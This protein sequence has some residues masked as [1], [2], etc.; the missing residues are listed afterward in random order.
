MLGGGPNAQR[1]HSARRRS[2]SSNMRSRH[3]R[4]RPHADRAGQQGLA[5]RVPSRRPRRHDHQ[6]RCSTKVPG[7]RSADGRGRDLGLRR[8]PPARRATTSP[9]SPRILAGHRRRA[10]RHREP[11][12]LVV[13]AD[14]PHGRARDQGRRGRRLHRRRRRDG[15]PVP[16]R[17]PTATPARTTRSSPTPRR[18]PRRARRRPADSWTPPAGLPD[19]YIAMG[20]TAENVAEIEGVTPR[21][22][23][24]VRR[25]VAAARRRVAGER[26]LR[27]GDHAGHHRPTA[28]SCRKDDGPRAGTTVEKLATL[29][30]VF[31]PDGKVTAGNACPLNDGAAAVVVMS[32]TKAERA[33][34]HAARPHRRQRRE[35]RS[36]RR[37]WASA[38]SRRAARR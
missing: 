14:D 13:A 27:A 12:L 17:Q 28:R 25:A 10:R 37:S 36:T 34:H 29:K 38:R 20:Q 1:Y 23:G 7:A 30:P 8:S 26:V 22:D 15:E 9:A 16:E 2:R 3:R 32:D 33:R 4:H 18:A 21:G 5:R 11:L 19:V 31:R 6:R 24:R 35:R